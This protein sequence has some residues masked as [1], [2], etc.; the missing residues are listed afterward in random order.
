M[1]HQNTIDS[2]QRLELNRRARQVCAV[3][4]EASRPMTDREITEVLGSED[5]NHA[6]P[7][8]TRLVAN[9]IIVEDSNTVCTVTK[10]TVRAT[11]L[12]TDQERQD[13]QPTDTIRG[14][15]KWSFI[16]RH[17]NLNPRTTTPKLLARV[18]QEQE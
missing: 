17:Y 2:W 3:L 7:S 8:I 11:R 13:H 9:G 18:I 12:A 15:D 6:R 1:I 16:C 5:M 10:R 4:A 14:G